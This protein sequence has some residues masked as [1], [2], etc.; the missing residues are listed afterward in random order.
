MIF[1]RIVLFAIALCQTKLSFVNNISISDRK[2]CLSVST[3][4][5]LN[6]K[7][8]KQINFFLV[9]LR[10]RGFHHPIVLGIFTSNSILY[11]EKCYHTMFKV[12]L[13]VFV[14]DPPGL[15]ESVPV[16]AGRTTSRKYLFPL[17]FHPSS[18][19][20]LVVTRCHQ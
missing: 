14:L 6:Q 18:T 1:I 11:S 9:Y 3:N 20:V 2:L 8:E 19:V 7:S 5:S 15:K 13:P 17:V 10:L 16:R 12:C 4:K